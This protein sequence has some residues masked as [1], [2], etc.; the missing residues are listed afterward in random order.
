MNRFEI[1]LA[2]LE[3][4]V[5]ARAPPGFESWRRLFGHDAAAPAR[6]HA[7]HTLIGLAARVA[8]AAALPGLGRRL[9]EPARLGWLHDD[10]VFRAEGLANFPGATP[11]DAIAAATPPLAAALEA[12]I[13]NL[14]AAP[15]RADLY[16]YQHLVPPALRHALGEVYTPS[17]LAAH[18]L[19]RLG[20]QPGH[21]LLDPT[22]GGGVFLLEALRRRQ[23][24]GVA[25]GQ[26]LDGLHG[27]DINPLAVLTAR[28]ALALALAPTLDRARPLTLPVWQGSVFDCS[29]IEMIPR[30]GFIAGNP[31][32]LK[33]SRLPAGQAEALKPLCRSLGLTGDDYYV[34]GIETDLS[35]LV[36]HAVLARWLAPGGRLAFYLTASLFS[37][38]SGRGFRRFAL[39]E[40]PGPCRVLA[41]DDFKAQTPFDGVTVHPALLLLEA[42][43]GASRWPVPY[44]VHQR[45]GRV[46]E[47]LAA[48]LPGTTDG[49]WLKGSAEQHRL[50]QRLFDATAPA[51]YRARKGVTTDR[52][53]IYFVTI[54][55]S[56]TDLFRIAND[57]ALGRSPSLPRLEA[58]IEGTHLFPLLRGRGLGPFA[59]KP[60]PE[61]RLILPQ[62]GMH[63]DP[64]LP[65]TCPR[66]H[67]YFQQFE[68]ELRRRASYRRYQAG[69]PFWSCW[70]TGPYTFSPWKVLWR[71][72]ASR[73]A[74][75]Y[76]GPVADPLLGER[77]AIPDHKL[78]FVPVST[79]DEAA[80][81]TGLLNAPLVS[82]AVTSYAAALGLGTGVIETL[83]I[84]RF[85]AARPQHRELSALAQAITARG[86]AV[87]PGEA[88]ALDRLALA[89]IAG[90]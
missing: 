9:A 62:H 19:D 38:A 34:G 90:L 42:G 26:L 56:D 86:G 7:L 81:L 16:H 76:L 6:L 74:A 47:L 43:G 59:I 41:V 12:L 61:L 40:P 4:A 31:P 48:P 79:E 58:A 2:A 3:A 24:A 29:E 55:K 66:T 49:P 23:A 35:A 51:A 14:A 69:Q 70:S 50:W 75:A 5:L 63:G 30:V 39:P 27:L 88:V 60:D 84:P 1:A 71:E 83:R 21:D 17:R 11:F 28:A 22:C 10:A 37:S 33:A 57:P 46:R 8:V 32:W 78:Y 36:T 52:N 67:A 15:P 65:R 64:E 68:A 20:W 82:E 85:D 18:A 13:T 73:F 53:G 87:A 89:L 45:D 44:R 72:I 80:Y 77:I 25:P 54:I